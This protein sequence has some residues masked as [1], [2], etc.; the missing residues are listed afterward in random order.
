MMHT[1][2]CWCVSPAASTNEL[3][4][5]L[6]R[7]TWTLCTGFVVEEHP[8][9]LFLNDSTHEDGAGEWA[10]VKVIASRPVNHTLVV[11]RDVAA[12]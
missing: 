1:R 9:Y 4:E 2:R 5:R 10:V 12:E 7:H 11:L 3:A 8:T 6:S